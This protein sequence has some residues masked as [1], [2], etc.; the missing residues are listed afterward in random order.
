MSIIN[1]QPLIGASGQGGGYNLTKSLRFRSSAS[2][3]LDRTMTTATNN[4]KWTWSAWVKRGKLTDTNIVFG[5]GDGTSDNFGAMQFTSGDVIQYSQI[6]SSSYVVQVNTN[7]VFRDP[8]AWYHVVLVYD[9]PNATSTDRIQIYVNGTRQ[10]VTYTTGPFAQNT[11]SKI[12]SALAHYISKLDYASLY[13]DG[14]LTE[15]N[16]IDGQALT[17]S[18]FGETSTSTGV[19]IPK[20]YTGTYGTNG[21]YLPFTDVATTSGSNAGLGKDFSGN[22]NY[23]TTNNIS[24]TTGTTYDSMS[25]VPTLT[26][27]TAA[28]YCTLNPLDRNTNLA[29]SNGNLTAIPS[30]DADYWL[31]RATMQLPS[32]GKWYWELTLNN[33]PYLYQAGIYSANRPNSGGTSATGNEYQVAWGTAWTYIM[34]QSN[35]AAFAAWG[36]NTNPTS[37]NVLMFAVDSDNGTMWV[38]RNGTWYNTSGTA[39]PATNT[40]PRF[41]SIPSGLFAGVNLP[42]PASGGVSMNFGQQGFAYTPPSGF[43]A[44]NTFNLPTP[45]IG[46]TASSQ[47]NDYFNAVTYTGTGA[48]QSITG[49]DFQPD[50]VWIKS[51]NNAGS[52]HLIDAV[53]GIPLFLF[54]D[55][56]AADTSRPNSFTSFNSNGFTV[57]SSSDGNTNLNTYTYVAWNWKANGSGSTNTAGSITSTVSANT[58]AGFSI[59]T[60]TGNNTLSTVGHG[61][62]VSPAFIIVK[63][64]SASNPWVTYHQSLGVQYYTLLSATDASYN[65]LANYWGSSAPTSTTFSINAYGGINT[66]GD[67][68]VAYCFAEVAGYSKFGSYTGNGSTDGPFVY[69]GFRPKFV[70]VKNTVDPNNWVTFDSARNTYNIIVS[71]LYPNASDAEATGSSTNGIDFLS[72]GFKIRS[73]NNWGNRNGDTIIYMAFAE[74]PFKFSNAR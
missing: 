46:A 68:Y 63:D 30:T 47:A 53:R 56:T 21:F 8:S 70:I 36:T 27:A 40:D 71:Q 50:F 32:T 38:G 37:G 23:W 48:T 60:Y 52:N 7:A 17:P 59:V 54:S 44:L 41:S 51:R 24:V 49:L 5:A 3:Y 28:N 67:N 45:T 62:G 39:N 42:N 2:A 34:Y 6:N 73:S 72:N 18:S 12:N 14:Y 1:S 69:T 35:N 55:S 31:G 13:F 29:I 22:G 58:T 64:R 9:S 16:F 61:L 25:D 57:G 43:K 74:N 19:W 66:N 11:S 10:S 33:T 20:K 15:V 26:S 4:L 65:N